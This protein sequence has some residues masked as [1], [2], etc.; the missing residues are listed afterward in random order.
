MTGEDGVYVVPG[1]QSPVVA[2]ADARL[3][4]ILRK[5][6]GHAR[7]S[8]RLGV[9]HVDE[10]LGILEVVDIRRIVLRTSCRACYQLGELSRE[11]DVRGLLHVEEG[12][13]VEYRGKPLRVLF[14]V[15]VQAPDGVP[16]RFLAHTYLRDKGL[17]GEMHQRTP[18]LEVLREVVLP[19]Q[20]YHRLALH[21]VV[22]VR[23][24]RHV[25]VGAGVDDA[26]V[27]DGHLACGIVHRVVAAFLQRHA[28]CRHH[29]RPLGHV[30]G[31]QRDDVG[32]AS[33]V[34]SCH[35]ELVLLSYLL[36]HGLGGV[37]ELAVD[38][39]LGHVARQ[40]LVHQLLAQVV[41]EGLCGW[42]EHATIIDRIPTHKVEEAIGV[43]LVIVVQTVT[44]EQFQQRHVFHPLFRY[45]YKVY[46]CRVTLVLDVEPEVALLHRRG[47]IVD[48]F[49]HQVPV[50]L[51]GI[52][53]RILQ[54]LHEEGLTGFGVVTGKLAHLIGL[55]SVCELIGHGQ[56]LV[57]LQSRFQRDIA[58]GFV[59]CVFRRTE[60]TGTGEL[61]VVHAS[62]KVADT[63]QYAAGL[64]DVTGLGIVARQ[65][66][67]FGIGG[68]AGHGLSRQ[69]PVAAAHLGI[70]AQVCQRDDV[71]G[72]ARR[73]R[74]IGDPHLHTGDLDARG[75]VGQRGH[76]RVVVVA[77]ILCQ[78]EVPV[79]LVVGSIHLEGGS[80]CPTPR[81]D[82]LRGGVLLRHHRLQLQPAELHVGT[83]TE[84]A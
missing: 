84:E 75:Q 53:R 13:L 11:G 76:G 25:H 4:G 44:A 36:S 73:S 16:Q 6:S 40:S 52:V 24:Q 51:L 69:L 32:R 42:Q 34:L 5:E 72:V 35:H 82:T 74:T 15:H 48:V 37:V 22:G 47:Q 78:E 31:I 57:C 43:G 77:E 64:V 14:P 7:Q 41:A 10:G 3:V 80:L 67:I 71:A 62:L 56:H 38:V 66:L 12:Y 23:L 58:E 63:C 19:V 20:A 49:H 65:H 29:Y 27:Q 45:I 70:L 55:S 1:Q 21:A 61:L 79:L 83:D 8:P 26:L 39:L 9:A 17:F 33:L 28:S 18:Q 30:V 68:I 59:Q 2:A 46:A 81:R 54:R 50:A 60:Q